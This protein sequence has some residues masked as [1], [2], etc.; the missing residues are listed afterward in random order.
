M[1][2]PAMPSNISARKRS[3][4]PNGTMT[5][6]ASVNSMNLERINAKNADRLARLENDSELN[7]SHLFQSPAS[8]LK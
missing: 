8:A 2:K 1:A 4:D 6:M 5:S 3:V 7:N